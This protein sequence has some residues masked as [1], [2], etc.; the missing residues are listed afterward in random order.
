MKQAAHF[1]TS[2]RNISLEKYKKK[3]EVNGFGKSSQPTPMKRVELI[4]NFN[5]TSVR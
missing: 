4:C 2:N 3:K 1:E 5:G